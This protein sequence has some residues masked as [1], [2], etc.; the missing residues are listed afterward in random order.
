MPISVSCIGH[1]N[2]KKKP[3]NIGFI[4]LKFKNNFIAHINVN[5]LSPVKI[6]QTLIAGSKKMVVYNDLEPSEKIKIYDKG[7][8]KVN[9]NDSIKDT[10]ISY[11]TGDSLIPKIGNNEAL[12]VASNEFI[13]CIRKKK[14]PITNGEVGLKV[15]SIIEKSITYMK[16]NG[17]TVKI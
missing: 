1:S 2:I 12:L 6:R 4:T 10:L 13:D 16:L 3:E 7:V 15:V 5:W 11:R 9:T 17:K 14:S 8:S